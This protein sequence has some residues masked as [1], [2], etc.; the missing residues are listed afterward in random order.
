MIAQLSIFDAPVIPKARRTDPATS[1]EAASKVAGRVSDL[2]AIVLDALRAAPAGL[3]TW[4]IAEAT[5]LSLVTVSPRCKPLERKG[6][7]RRE[8]RRVNRNGCSSTV[9]VVE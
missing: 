9:W 2:E 1:R 5:G 7:V 4:E 6:L 8:G 3:T